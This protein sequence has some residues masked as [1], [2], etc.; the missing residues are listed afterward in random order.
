M[1]L[2]I[3][4]SLF[5]AF[6]SSEP[7]PLEMDAEGSLIVPAFPSGTACRTMMLQLHLGR[8]DL[9]PIQRLGTNQICSNEARLRPGE[10]L[11]IEAIDRAGQRVW[12]TF[13]DDLRSIDRLY[14][15]PPRASLDVTIYVPSGE[16][17]ELLRWYEVTEANTL[18]LIGETPWQP[19]T[20]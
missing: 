10:N 9:Q 4:L 5:S 15:R 14:R 2:N 18:Q 19:R 17:V 20:P 3:I 8:P 12:V 1:K 7:P 16:N 6:A 13:T 11:L